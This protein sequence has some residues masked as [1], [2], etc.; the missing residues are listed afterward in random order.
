MAPSPRPRVFLDTNVILSGLYSP[1]GA[2]AKVLRLA[3]EGQIQ[4]VI[5]RQ[6]LEELVRTFRSKLPD[7]LEALQR[8]LTGFLPEVQQDPPPEEVRRWNGVIGQ[9]DAPIL[10]A[11]VQAKPDYL[12]TGDKR[13]MAPEVAR[14]SGLRIL[15]PRE[16]LEELSVETKE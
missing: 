14:E 7:K 5:S 15:Y 12:V 2:P 10:A 9:T 13:F 6:V 16:L 11:A 4:V 8:F 1:S 3:I